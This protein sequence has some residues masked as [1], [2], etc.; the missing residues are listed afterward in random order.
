M[1][2]VETAD[3]EPVG[4]ASSGADT[5]KGRR[6]FARVGREFTDEEMLSSGVQKTLLDDTE[7]LEAECAALRGYMEKFHAADKRAA[8]LEERIKPQTAIDIFAGGALAVG[9]ALVGY[10][11]NVWNE[12]PTGWISLILGGILI[13]T[14]IMAKKISK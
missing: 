5:P 7:R 10:A 3:E 11:P 2:D 12:Q 4:G 9:S 8:I 13:V 6:S 1:A 14:G